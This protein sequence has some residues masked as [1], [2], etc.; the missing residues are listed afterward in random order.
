[1]ITGKF[2]FISILVL[3][4]GTYIGS[5]SMTILAFGSGETIIFVA[6]TQ[7]TFD[8]FVLNFGKALNISLYRSPDRG[9]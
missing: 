6:V 5:L 1:M 3:N 4:G 7:L 2:A 8:L 9:N